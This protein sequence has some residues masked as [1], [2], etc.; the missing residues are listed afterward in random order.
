MHGAS[1]N[2]TEFKLPYAAIILR[3]TVSERCEGIWM[4]ATVAYFVLA[5]DG[6][7]MLQRMLNITG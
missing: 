1:L 7:D 2:Y 3:T 6:R 5:E 4:D